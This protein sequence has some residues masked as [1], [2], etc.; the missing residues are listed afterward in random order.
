MWGHFVNQ[1][2]QNEPWKH[3]NDELV[4]RIVWGHSVSQLKGTSRGNTVTMSWLIE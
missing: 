2:I 4:E 1:R 3:G